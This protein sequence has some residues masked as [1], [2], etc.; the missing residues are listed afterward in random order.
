M[1]KLNLLG[2]QL[3][4][5][6]PP[7]TDGSFFNIICMH[8]SLLFWQNYL[9]ISIFTSSSWHRPWRKKKKKKK[10][11][12]LWSR[13]EAGLKKNLYFPASCAKFPSSR[14]DFPYV[15]LYFSLQITKIPCKELPVLLFFFFFC[16]CFCFF[17]FRP[18]LRLNPRPRQTTL[19]L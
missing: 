8:H 6:L 7:W 13:Y 12:G 14:V 2:G 17:F 19:F 4:C 11:Q 15:F 10:K 5:Y 18:G 9:H 3:T 1:D 16:F